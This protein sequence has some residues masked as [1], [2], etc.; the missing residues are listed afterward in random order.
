MTAP[1]PPP[2]TRRRRPE[3]DVQ[4]LRDRLYRALYSV[5]EGMHAT[6]QQ[7]VDRYARLLTPALLNREDQLPTAAGRPCMDESAVACLRHRMADAVA[8]YWLAH[9]RGEERSAR[10]LERLAESVDWFE[11]MADV[12]YDRYVVV[13][14][15]GGPGFHLEE[16]TG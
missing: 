13:Q 6:Q 8:A 14:N 12:G 2:P 7:D 9:D 10:G 5:R 3:G 1:G 16:S 11:A 15:E 4:T